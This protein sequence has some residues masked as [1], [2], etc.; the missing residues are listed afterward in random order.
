[1]WVYN[2]SIPQHVLLGREENMRY[3]NESS[4][5]L[6]SLMSVK[7]LNGHVQQRW[8]SGHGV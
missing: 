7:Q 2:A 8:V 1:M 4:F 3:A 5:N 6:L